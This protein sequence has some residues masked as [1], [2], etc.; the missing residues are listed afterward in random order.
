MYTL[1]TWIPDSSLL[2]HIR[3]EQVGLGS[4]KNLEIMSGFKSGSV[5]KINMMDLP[6]LCWT[7]VSVTMLSDSGPLWTKIYSPIRTLTHTEGTDNSFILVIHC[8]PLSSTAEHFF[9]SFH[10]FLNVSK[11]RGANRTKI[12]FSCGL[13]NQQTMKKNL[14]TLE[15]FSSSLYPRKDASAYQ[16]AHR[17]TFC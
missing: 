11:S 12:S 7:G 4:D 10:Y 14:L 15:N 2:G 3:T 13:L 6:V 5:I 1:H 8:L 17:R 9:H 16:S